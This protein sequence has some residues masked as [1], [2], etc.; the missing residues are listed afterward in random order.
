MTGLSFEELVLKAQ[1]GDSEA[2]EE[3]IVN[4]MRLVYSLANRYK[5]STTDYEDI[6]QQ[7][8]IGLIHAIM[9][10]DIKKGVMFST[11]AVPLILGEIKKIVRENSILKIGRVTREMSARLYRRVEEMQ[12]ELGRSPTIEEISAS[13]DISREK[14]V[15]LINS[16]NQVQSMDEALHDHEDAYNKIQSGEDTES[17]AVNNI[18]LDS[19]VSSID[20]RQRKILYLRYYRD[21]TQSEVAKILGISQ[22]QV[23]RIEKQL[24]LKLRKLLA[25]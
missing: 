10:F 22:V 16:S 19:I 4:N 18:L 25:G 24:L 11:Y 12:T 8:T 15:F 5:S 13:L 21:K 14:A 3:L 2:K 20:G 23:S 6:V 17:C 9:R 1:T 7:G